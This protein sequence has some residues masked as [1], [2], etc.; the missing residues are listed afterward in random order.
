YDSET[1]AERAA[2]DDDTDVNENSEVD[3]G[4]LVKP[5]LSKTGK[6]IFDDKN[7]IYEL[8]W[9]GYRTMASVNKGKVQL[10]SRNGLS[11]NKKF[12]PIAESLRALDQDAIIDG[13][14]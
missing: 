13:E 6:K 4:K 12:A 8:K 3:I 9:D 14:M 5:M 11:Q 7:W 10:Y 1:F 2:D